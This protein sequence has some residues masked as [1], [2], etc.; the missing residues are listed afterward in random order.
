MLAMVID[1]RNRSAW[2]G[3]ESEQAN[4][5]LAQYVGGEWG[6]QHHSGRH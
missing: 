1:V 4:V 3:V 5:L 2:S 6:E